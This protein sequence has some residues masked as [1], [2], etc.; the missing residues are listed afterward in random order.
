M[1]KRRPK[2]KNFENFV[3]LEKFI[4]NNN[5]PKSLKKEKKKEIPKRDN[6]EISI[7]IKRNIELEEENKILKEKIGNLE[8]IIEDNDKIDYRKISA[9]NKDEQMVADV[10]NDMKKDDGFKENYEL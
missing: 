4:K 9:D 1:A 10:I 2:L 5:Q 6:N 8:E 3:S 7:I